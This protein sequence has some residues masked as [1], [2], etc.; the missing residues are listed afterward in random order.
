MKLIKELIENKKTFLWDP[1]IVSIDAV[2]N[3]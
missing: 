1:S 2:R 3:Y